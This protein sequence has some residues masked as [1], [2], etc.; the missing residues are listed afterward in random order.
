M[1]NKRE[2]AKKEEKRTEEAEER[3]VSIRKAWKNINY[4]Y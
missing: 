4:Y 2:G 3:R 1:L